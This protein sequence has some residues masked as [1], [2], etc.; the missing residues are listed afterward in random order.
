M[1]VH[2]DWRQQK[3][4]KCGWWSEECCDERE[5]ESEGGWVSMVGRFSRGVLP[6]SRCYSVY[7]VQQAIDAHWSVFPLEWFKGETGF[8]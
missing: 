8:D 2:Q 5:S 4:S 3:G 1:T 6:S 7:E